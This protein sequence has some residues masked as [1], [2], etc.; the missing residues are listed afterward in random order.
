[1][2]TYNILK[3]KVDIWSLGI[4]VIE[5]VE[6]EPPYM[7]LPALKVWVL[8]KFINSLKYCEP[9]INQKPMDDLQV[10]SYNKQI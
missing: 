8:N 1:M 2:L 5:L 6:I 10:S 7:D 3:L 9:L 4:M